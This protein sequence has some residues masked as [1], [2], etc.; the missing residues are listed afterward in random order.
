SVGTTRPWPPS[1]AI[2]STVSCAPAALISATTT[3]APSRANSRADARPIP[4]PAPVMTTTRSLRSMAPPEIFEPS[5]SSP[6]EFQPRTARGEFVVRPHA[7]GP[8]MSGLVRVSQKHG[9]HVSL[10]DAKVRL[11]QIEV[12]LGALRHITSDELSV[13][14]EP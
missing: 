9:Q 4:E 11:R 1:F 7:K 6:F 2:S 3:R 10:P 5:P 12:F 13:E 8:N 14:L